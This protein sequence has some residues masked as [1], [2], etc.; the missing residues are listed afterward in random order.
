MRS[1]EL[2][3]ELRCRI[4]V[5][6]RSRKDYKNECWNKLNVTKWTV[7]FVILNWKKFGTA[8]TSQS[9]PSNKD[10]KRVLVGQV[11]PAVMLVELLASFVAEWLND[12]QIVRTIF[13]TLKEP[14]SNF[15]ASILSIIWDE[16]PEWGVWKKYHFEGG[17]HSGFEQCQ[18][19]EF[20]ARK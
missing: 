9:W 7:I 3:Q 4:M 2:I 10:G 18:R 20:V 1:K 17:G 19:D 6:Y 14:R 12:S 13:F 11:N 15:L 8:R 5:L 16:N